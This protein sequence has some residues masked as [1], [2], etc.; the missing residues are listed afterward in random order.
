MTTVNTSYSTTQSAAAAAAA[1][2]AASQPAI[3]EEFNSFIKL[4]TAQ[5]RNQDPLAPL[6]STQFVEQLATFSALE[7]QVRSNSSLSSIATMMNDMTG[8]LAGQWLGQ[9]VSIQTAKVP[10]TGNTI[11]FNV[12]VPKSTAS[13]VLTIKDSAGQTVWTETLDPASRTHT[14]DGQ[15]QSGAMATTG[16]AYTFSID[17][18]D[19]ANVHTGTKLPNVITSVTAI[20]SEEGVLTVNTAAQL[21]SALGNVKKI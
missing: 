5:M 13:S 8:L 7:Q 18:Y 16:E 21:T 10:Y 6:D 14:W 4:L 3:G 9:S 20:S 19:A 12:D 17:T 15:L 1:A 11:E 2:S